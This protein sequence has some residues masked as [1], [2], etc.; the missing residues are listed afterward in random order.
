MLDGGYFFRATDQGRAVSQK[1]FLGSVVNNRLRK[2]L[3]GAKLN[4]GETP[5]SSRLGLSN[6]LNMLGCSHDD[7]SRYLVWRSGGKARHYTRM[8]KFTP[9]K[10]KNQKN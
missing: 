8:S 4:G 1:P 6:T 7:I 5:H 10:N 3:T 9:A 2:H